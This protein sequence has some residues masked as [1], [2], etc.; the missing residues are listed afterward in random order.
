M[1]SYFGSWESS[2][3]LRSMQHATLKPKYQ[4]QPSSS[5]SDG[6][7][8]FTGDWYGQTFNRFLTLAHMIDFASR[9]N[10]I[11][12]GNRPL[13]QLDA[14]KYNWFNEWLDLEAVGTTTE[15]GGVTIV[16]STTT[17]TNQPCSEVRTAEEWYNFGGH[18][19]Y[20]PSLD[21]LRSTLRKHFFTEAAQVIQK[22]KEQHAREQQTKGNKHVTRSD[23]VRV[24]TVHS[25]G[26][27]GSCARRMNST[28]FQFCSLQAEAAVTEAMKQQEW[29][30]H[31]CE[32]NEQYV[33]QQAKSMG[34]AEENTAIILCSD[35]QQAA[36]DLTFQNRNKSS[37]PVQV[38]LMMMSDLHFGVPTSSIDAV[39]AHWR[40]GKDTFPMECYQN[41]IDRYRPWWWETPYA[42]NR[43][44]LVP[45]PQ[46]TA[47]SDQADPSVAP[48]DKQSSKL[49]ESHLR[50]CSQNPYVDA[51]VQDIN[52][53][54]KRMDTWLE[55]NNYKNILHE[56]ETNP[57]WKEKWGPF[58]SFEKMMSCQANEKDCIGGGCRDDTSKIT[59]GTKNLKPGCVV[60]SIGG[61]NQWQFEMG[62]LQKTPCQ[63]H[64]FDCTG[65][66]SRFKVPANDRLVFHHVCLGTEHVD[67]A[68][69][70]PKGNPKCGPTWTLSEMQQTLG[71]NR[72]DLLKVDIEGFEWGLFESWPELAAQSEQ[73]QT[74][75]LPMQLNVEI[76]YKTQFPALW[77][78]GQTNDGEI[79]KSPTEIAGLQRH[80]LS[81]GYAVIE[82]DDNRF[83]PHCTELTLIR[84]RCA[85]NA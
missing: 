59:C 27:E 11:D 3:Q 38:A 26:L 14:D 71:H 68:P 56:A 36:T 46:V 17:T 34:Y 9:A 70:C 50:P 78:P 28:R 53:V 18:R 31:P 10:N 44:E 79:W 52:E 23:Q 33:R 72:I 42:P 1:G 82:R 80:L 58:N 8:C 55:P 24:V 6:P 20:Q 4:K 77:R 7:V 21:V 63:V 75:A 49:A 32:Y 69:T 45:S 43:K 81:M 73:Q 76:H 13:I 35:G 67:A 64:T 25:R 65:D 84:A 61:N 85:Q 83:C 15:T 12:N 74:L 22:Y 51:L 39:L 37:F 2:S 30:T 48:K 66:R 54:A 16:R 40:H 41:V 62:V 19:G 47:S 29:A 57:A 5:L 60:Y